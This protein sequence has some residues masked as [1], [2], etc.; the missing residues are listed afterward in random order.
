MLRLH[1]E[2][3]ELEQLEALDRTHV[4][5]H[6]DSLNH[7]GIAEATIRADWKD[8][9]DF[10]ATLS[11]LASVLAPTHAGEPFE[12]RRAR[13]VGVLADPAHAAALLTGASQTPQATKRPRRRRR[14]GVHLIVHTTRDALTG[15]DPVA[16]VETPT[17]GAGR[18]TLAQQVASWCARPET[19]IKVTEVIDLN[20][21]VEVDRYEI[22]D[23]LADRVDLTHPTCVFPWCT[24]PARRLKPHEHPCDRE[25]VVPHSQGGPTCTCQIAPLCRRHHRLKTHGGWTYH[26][27]EPGSYVWTSPHRYQYLRDHTGTLDVSRDRHRCHTPRPDDTPPTGHT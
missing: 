21:P 14:R 23:R 12:A 2:E 19:E 15:H 3:R 13:A 6:E 16:R 8:L 11:D 22:P 26:V 1:A 27:L 17:G 9:D 5:V 18:P 10:S 7:V 25:H 24:R 20:Q 4:T